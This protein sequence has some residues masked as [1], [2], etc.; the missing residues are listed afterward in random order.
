M[1]VLSRKVNERILL[2]GDIR[3]TVTGIRGN[4]VRLGIEA[5]DRVEILRGE[6]MGSA[7]AGPS[8]VQSGRGRPT[9][10]RLP[11]ADREVP[12]PASHPDVGW[13]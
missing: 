13:K 1:L 9:S 10:G 7:P 6:L 2:S 4:R 8:P 5:P 12:S 3:I 11:G